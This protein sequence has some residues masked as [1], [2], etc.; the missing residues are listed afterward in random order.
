M[1]ALAKILKAQGKNVFGSDCTLS[2]ITKELTSA[3]IEVVKDENSDF[4]R[5]CDVC[6]YSGA[7]SPQ[8]PDVVL[9]E[10]LGKKILSRAQLLGEIAGDKKCIAIAGTHGK[11]TTTGMLATVMLK[12]GLDPTIHIGGVLNEIGGNLHIGSGEYFVTEACEYQDAFLSLKSD[13]SVLLNVEPDHLDYFKNLE[14]LNKSFEKFSKNTKNNGFCVINDNISL[15][16]PEEINA[17]S[18]GLGGSSFLQARNIRE[19]NSGRFCYSLYAGEE[20]L[21]NVYLSAYGRHNVENSLAVIGVSLILG[22]DIEIIKRGLA[23]YKGVE[24]RMQK[25]CDKPLI[26]HD[27]AHHPSEIRKT[28]EVCQSINEKVIVIFQPHTFS[29]TKD[30]YNEFLNCFAGASEVWILPIYPAREKPIKNITSAKLVEDLRE[31][32]CSAK[33]ISSFEECKQK[34]TACFEDVLFAILGAGD[35]EKLVKMFD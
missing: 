26:I 31:G 10:K 34:I 8:H 12:A 2:A 24:R 22:I 9:A 25:I 16:L 32:G 7:I 33:Y 19:Y 14:N 3:G 11:T 27:Y 28:I 17:L 20:Y 15:N 4:V 1:S 13:I 18:F 23:E 30:L 5:K 35:V 29:R 21:T 6:V